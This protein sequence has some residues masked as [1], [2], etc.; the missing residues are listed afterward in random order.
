MR[1]A[2]PLR[3]K[4][5]EY[6]LLAEWHGERTPL[7]ED[8]LVACRAMLAV[9]IALREVAEALDVDWWGTRMPAEMR[10]RSER[11]AIT[12]PLVK[13]QFSTRLPPEL[14]ERLRVASPQLDLRQSDIT[15]AAL[16][17]FLRR[18]GDGGRAISTSRSSCRRSPSASTRPF[19]SS[20]G[21]VTRMVGLPRTRSTRTAAWA[22]APSAWLRTVRRRVASSSMGVRRR[23]GL[24]T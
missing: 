23:S 18:R 14:L 3:A 4:S 24:P 10:R 22:C 8:H 11:R 21:A 7:D 9:G 16:D 5:G 12:A 20:A 19:R 13:V 6:E 15:A 2:E 17:T 1:V